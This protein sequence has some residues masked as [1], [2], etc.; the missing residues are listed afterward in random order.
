[1]D[2][3][4]INII[5]LTLGVVGA[6][7]AIS[8]D[9]W[10]RRRP[11]CRRLTLQGWVAAACLVGTLV[12]G[13]VREDLLAKAGQASSNQLTDLNTRL[14]TT[15]KELTEARQGIERGQR[16]TNNQLIQST[17]A[18]LDLG[19][20]PIYHDYPSFRLGLMWYWL[21]K[22]NPSPNGRKEDLNNAIYHFQRQASSRKARIPSLY[23]LGL[24]YAAIG[25]TE[26]AKRNFSKALTGNKSPEC[27]HLV[28]S[29]L[30][31]LAAV[32]AHKT[33]PRN[34]KIA[35]LPRVGNTTDS[36]PCGW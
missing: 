12:L 17:N 11:W 9:T 27:R 7:L 1:M 34:W 5:L 36:D 32:A 8:G 35:R 14:A 18:L 10:K 20:S 24:A 25:D 15:K 33:D 3:K 29:H 30:D 2:I 13:I 19:Y 31:S 28:K 21:Y 6:F 26:N 22:A 16:W 4:I 23:N